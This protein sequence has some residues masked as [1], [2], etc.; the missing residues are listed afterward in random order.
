MLGV[1]E[2]HDKVDNRYTSPD[3]EGCSST[4]AEDSRYYLFNQT[5]SDHIFQ[6]YEDGIVSEENFISSSSIEK[7]LP[8]WDYK[9]YSITDCDAIIS[10]KYS[11]FENFYKRLGNNRL[12]MEFCKYAF[13]HDKGGIFIRNDV[14][15]DRKMIDSINFGNLCLSFDDNN[16]NDR[17]MASP[18]GHPFWIDVMRNCSV[19]YWSRS[20]YLELDS[21]YSDTSRIHEINPVFKHVVGSSVMDDSIKNTNVNY[22]P[23]PNSL[24]RTSNN[25]KGSGAYIYNDIKS[26]MYMMWLAVI[27]I[28]LVFMAIVLLILIWM[29]ESRRVDEKMHLKD[30]LM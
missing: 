21:K 29:Y 16:V 20:S 1:G 28:V 13:L 24:I 9:I 15:V 19:N 27:S 14:I 25:I 18:P 12:R 30:K 17:V 26:K 8:E 11:D 3:I 22:R 6:M 5:S 7:C 4:Y 10:S 23:I 2:Q